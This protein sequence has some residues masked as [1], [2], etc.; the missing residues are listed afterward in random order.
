MLKVRALQDSSCNESYP[1]RW[2]CLRL[3]MAQH[4]C[5]TR[6]RAAAGAIVQ[7]LKYT[8]HMSRQP[9]L[10]VHQGRCPTEQLVYYLYNMCYLW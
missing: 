3:T 5:R 9:G 8:H 2:D 4:K 10:H 7:G 1:Q 6:Y